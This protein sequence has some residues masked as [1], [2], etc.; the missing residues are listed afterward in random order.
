MEVSKNDSFT[1]ASMPDWD[2]VPICSI[3][4]SLSYDLGVFFMCQSMANLNKL[5]LIHHRLNQKKYLSLPHNP[6]VETLHNTLH[7]FRY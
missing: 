3:K 2:E 7:E 1:D 6:V 4:T 5:F